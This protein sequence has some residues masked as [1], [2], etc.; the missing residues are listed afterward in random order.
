MVR[1]AFQPLLLLRFAQSST[2]NNGTPLVFCALLV[3]L[4]TRGNKIDTP[5]DSGPPVVH[6]IA[7]S[8]PLVGKLQEGDK[9]IAVDGEDVSDMTATDVS[10]LIGSKA[11][12]RHRYL[13]VIRSTR[14]ASGQD[15]YSSGQDDSSNSMA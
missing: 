14:G 11:T 5:D 3:F 6:D 2:H 15:D 9:L 7:D 1:F 12:N 13:R 10:A 4:H 8:S